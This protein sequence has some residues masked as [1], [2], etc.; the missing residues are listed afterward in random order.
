[1]P[2]HRE[3]SGLVSW[4]D[5][6]GIREY[7]RREERNNNN[8]SCGL[9]F[10]FMIPFIPIILPCFIM[11]YIIL[12]IIIY[13]IAPLCDIIYDKLIDPLF[14]LIQN[15]IKEHPKISVI[16]GLMILLY[17]YH[18]INNITVNP[19]RF[20]DPRFGTHNKIY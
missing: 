2:W 19:N 6:Y 3:S 8:T 10:V 13:I 20:R 12:Y 9:A 1:M 4:K 18:M 17:I 14:I 16:I 7:E 15:K 11:Y 5:S